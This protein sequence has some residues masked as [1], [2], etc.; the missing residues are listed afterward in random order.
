M[1]RRKPFS[2]HRHRDPDG[3][4]DRQLL[5]A[6]E[7]AASEYGW[8]TARIAEE[9]TDELLVTYLDAATD[10]ERDANRNWIEF[11]RIG[12]IFAHDQ[13]AYQRWKRTETKPTGLGLTGSSLEQAVMHTRA[14]A[15]AKVVTE[16]VSAADMAARRAVAEAVP[17]VPHPATMLG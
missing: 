1:G 9:L 3:D 8:S 13:K 15:G 6:Y 11:V 14:V 4:P 5:A 10:R 16:Q 12:T 2:R 7:Y 17:L